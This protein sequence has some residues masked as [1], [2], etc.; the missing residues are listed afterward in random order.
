M[1][2]YGRVSGVTNGAAASATEPGISTP[3]DDDNET[4]VQT[5]YVG[6][7]AGTY[8]PAQTIS[9]TYNP[10]CSTA[11][12]ATPAGT[13]SYGY[14]ADGRPNSLTN[15]FSETSTWTYLDSAGCARFVSG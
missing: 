7:T 10:S 8:L 6:Q 15:P 12:M 2:E 14:D 1:T 9:Y 3:Y 4:S 5:T 11:S 13:F